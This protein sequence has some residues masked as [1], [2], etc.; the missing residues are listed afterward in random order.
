ML[1]KNILY[2][3]QSQIRQ[4]FHSKTVVKHLENYKLMQNDLQTVYMGSCIDN[5]LHAINI[6][7]HAV[8]VGTYLSD[9]GTH[10]RM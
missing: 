5:N 4:V 7:T 8:Q 1:I 9:E 10:Q 6:P 2:I 3:V